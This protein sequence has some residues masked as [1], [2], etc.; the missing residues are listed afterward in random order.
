MKRFVV[1]SVRNVII[2]K[3]VNVID[4]YGRRLP[5]LKLKN[6]HFVLVIKLL[7]KVLNLS[8]FKYIFKQWDTIGAA[9]A[10]IIFQQ[11]YN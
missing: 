11:R 8:S 1:E 9:R 6:R 5:L 4:R 2:C 10:L 3:Q 7:R